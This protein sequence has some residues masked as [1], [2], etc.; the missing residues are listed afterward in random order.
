M[1]LLNYLIFENKRL[2]IQLKAGMFWILF[3]VVQWCENA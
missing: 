3:N 2:L 1:L